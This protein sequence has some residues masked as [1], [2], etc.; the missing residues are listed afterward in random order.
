[1][2]NKTTTT[3]PSPEIHLPDPKELEEYKEP[4]GK[5]ILS[6]IEYDLYHEE[7][8]V[9]HTI[10]RV[11]RTCV[12]GREK[13]RI[14]H[15][16]TLIRTI[17]GGKLLKKEKEFLRTIEGV[18]FLIREHSEKTGKLKSFSKLHKAIKLALTSK[19]S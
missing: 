4:G 6:K 7:L 12:A 1:M 2:K 13:W 5:L 10:T 15:N 19:K 14:F 17:D 18:S 9:Q 16:S 11:K 8:D 3:K